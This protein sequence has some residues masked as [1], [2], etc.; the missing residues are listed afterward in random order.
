MDSLASLETC[1]AI[2]VFYLKVGDVGLEVVAGNAVFV[3]CTGDT[4]IV[5][6]YSIFQISAAFS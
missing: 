2:L 5:F 1:F 4:T 6:F 3:N